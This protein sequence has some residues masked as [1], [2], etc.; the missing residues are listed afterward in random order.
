M[1]P[2]DFFNKANKKEV[3]LLLLLISKRICLF[4][5]L[6]FCFVALFQKYRN[7]NAENLNTFHNVVSG[8]VIRGVKDAHL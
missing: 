2:T 8:G 3:L 6:S 7:G 1:C 5:F 4:G